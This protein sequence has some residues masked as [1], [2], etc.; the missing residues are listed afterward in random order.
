[1]HPVYR[2]SGLA[3]PVEP[4]Y[5]TNKAIAIL[6]PITAVLGVVLRRS[7]GLE[8]GAAALAG[9]GLGLLVFLVWALTREL[10]PDDNPAAFL[11][12]AL[13]ALA[14]TR[15]GE[16][17]LVVVG[18]VLIAAR[19][20]N[21]S[22]GMPAKIHDSVLVILG[23][24]LAAWWSSWTLG[25]VGALALT[26]DALLPSRQ[27]RGR[28]QPYLHLGGAG[29]VAAVVVGRLL[30][31]VTAPQL[32]AH[33]PVFAG[34]VGLG[35]LAALG[36]PRPRACG[37]V[38]G[39]PLQPSRVRAGLALGVLAAALLAIDA[40]FRLQAS[41]GLWA[42]VLASALGLPIVWLRLKARDRSR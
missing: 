21:R 13:A 34:I 16:Q 8:W 12:V 40:D 10:S 36:Y 15:V 6:T 7:E 32:P 38:D 26:L 23:F 3:R 14:W 41:S 27:A 25:V 5:P 20:V 9:L 33:L 17:S 19:M 39:Q 35:V 31:G 22:T 11:A 37:D 24:G 4:E 1:M 18:V 30:V 28:G 42:A 2:M 29:L